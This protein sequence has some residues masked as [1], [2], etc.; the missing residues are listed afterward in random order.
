MKLYTLFSLAGIIFQLSKCIH[1]RPEVQRNILNFGYGINY[2]YGGM[3]AHSFD[4]FYEVTKFMLPMIGDIKFSKL[5]Y[6]NTCMYMKKEFT[7]NTDSRKY[8]TELRT[9][10]NKIKPFISY[11]SKCIHTTE[12]L[13]TYCKMKSSCYYLKYQDKN[14]E[15]SPHWYKIS[16]F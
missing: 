11:Y 6:D 2:K 10:C 12:Q 9:Y 14:M 7:P 15:L 3:L 13:I 5:N 8:L 4:R 16:L 1:I